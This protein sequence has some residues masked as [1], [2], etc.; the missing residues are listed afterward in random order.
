V[1]ERRLRR[2]AATGQAVARGR[3]HAG[4]GLLPMMTGGELTGGWTLEAKTAST[5]TEHVEA[6]R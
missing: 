2:S 6:E 3:G 5:C 1:G 4:K